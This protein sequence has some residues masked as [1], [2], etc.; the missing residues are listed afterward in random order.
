MTRVMTAS[1][2]RPNVQTNMIWQYHQE[3]LNLRDEPF[4]THSG[5]FSLREVIFSLFLHELFF[6]VTWNKFFFESNT[7]KSEKCQ[8]SNTLNEKPFKFYLIVSCL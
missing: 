8:K 3:K 1:G 6:K 5:G 7:L 4:D 2:N